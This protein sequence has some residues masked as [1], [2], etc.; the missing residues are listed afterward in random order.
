M[1]SSYAL[2]NDCFACYIV[3][4]NCFTILTRGDGGPAGM[5][6]KVINEVPIDSEE[7]KGTNLASPIDPVPQYSNMEVEWKQ[8]KIQ[9]FVQESVRLLTIAEPKFNSQ[10]DNPFYGYI[11]KPTNGF[12]AEEAYSVQWT[13]IFDLD[14]DTFSVGVPYH[15]RRMFHLQHIPRSLFDPQTSPN[16]EIFEMQQYRVLLDPVPR[17]HL[18]SISVPVEPNTALVDLYQS[19]SPHIQ[20]LLSIPDVATFHIRKYLRLHLSRIFSDSHRGVLQWIHT[21]KQ[22]RPHYSTSITEPASLLELRFRQ[23]V[24]GMVHLSSSSVEVQFKTDRRYKYPVEWKYLRDIDQEKPLQWPVPD[25]EYWI[26]NILVIQEMAMSTAENLH[27]AI[28]KAIQ[29]INARS[30][31]PT[32]SSGDPPQLVRAV[33]ISTS[34]LVVVDVCGSRVPIRPTCR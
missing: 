3:D 34:C 6:R 23:M 32:I 27:A 14:N 22:A 17:A 26:G 30:P 9:H 16:G 1:L 4:G 10:L 28:G 19:C 21:G 18:A 5:G 7:F 8:L 2:P 29:V 20:P 11:N 25:A 15:N 12:P 31:R 24:Y 33:I 13:Y